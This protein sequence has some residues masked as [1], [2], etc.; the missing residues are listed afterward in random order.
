ML[1][2]TRLFVQWKQVV[3]QI[4]VDAHR[5]LEANGELYVVIQKKQG[6]PSAK[7]KWKLFLAMSNQLKI[8][9]AIIF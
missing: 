3:H 5:V 4:F 1:S 7:K 9:R 2:Q 8:V 6:M